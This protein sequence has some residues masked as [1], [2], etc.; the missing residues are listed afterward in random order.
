[1]WTPKEHTSDITIK[2]T[3]S[4][5]T[6]SNALTE[7]VDSSKGSR[8]RLQTLTAS[9]I[10]ITAFASIWIF[11]ETQKLHMPGDNQ[12]RTSTKDIC[13]TVCKS[14]QPPGVRE[15]RYFDNASDLTDSN[16]ML[17]KATIA[18]NNLLEKLRED[19]GSFH[20]AH[21]FNYRPYMPIT[22]DGP[23]MDRLRRKLLIKI[24]SVQSKVKAQISCN[25]KNDN[26][27]TSL[28]FERYVWATGGH[29]SAAG[30]GNLFN[31]SYTAYMERD[32]VE[33][34]GSVGIE[35]EGRNYAMGS[36]TSAGEMSMCWEQIFGLDVDIF[37][38]DYGMTDGTAAVERMLHFGYRGGLSAGRPAFLV[39]QCSKRSQEAQVKALEEMGV[40]GFY[41]NE[42]AL[43]NMH[44]AI[45]DS[46][47]LTNKQLD[48]LPEYV[49]NWKCNGGIEKG[50]PYCGKEKYT[51][52][53]CSPRKLQT[54]WHP[55]FKEQAMIGHGIALF[56]ADALISALKSLTENPDEDV[57]SLLVRLRNEE[58]E[59]FANF[60]KATL[61]DNHKKLFSVD[62]TIQ[63]NI[64]PALFFRGRSFCHTARLPSQTRYLGHL[65]ETNKVG[66]PAPVGKE[67]YDVGMLL[68]EAMKVDAKGSMR[69][70]WEQKD[71]SRDCPV[72]LKPD[73][74][75]I[76]LATSKDGWVKRTLP[77]EA[78]KVAY[79]YDPTQFKGIIVFYLRGCDW[80]KC[81]NGFLKWQDYAE[82][83]WEMRVNGNEIPSVFDIGY[84]GVIAK[85]ND[86]IYFPPNAQGT[87]DIEIKV[88]EDDSFVKVSSFVL[89]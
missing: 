56:L 8:S 61:P 12:L 66:G 64:D 71:R 75:D 31:E 87:Y 28:F 86:G 43:R 35:F 57:D 50:E 80:G 49:R 34:F 69:L 60:T 89:Y 24:L 21:I 77:N 4:I 62:D 88:N 15:N 83:K 13:D 11:S 2:I 16:K 72:T 47:R 41:G 55:G 84:D 29:S 68:D 76:F 63:P 1:L 36:A 18:K 14:R 54:S 78:E 59:L 67:T 52:N 48:A 40:A 30:H 7:K 5:P 20:F 70:V 45:P 23:S 82:K 17:N 81:E 10:L 44:A 85:G 22:P 27:D 6:S 42:D 32:L 37:S 39:V 51:S 65:T 79:Q 26:L 53:V 33:L 74:K 3:M 9:L 46:G 19:Y 38:W 58:E 73:Y 25:C